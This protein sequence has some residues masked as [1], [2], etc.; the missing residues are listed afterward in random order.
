MKG[1]ILAEVDTKWSE[2]QPS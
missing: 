2:C 1:D